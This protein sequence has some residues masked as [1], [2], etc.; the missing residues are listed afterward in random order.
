MIDFAAD[1]ITNIREQIGE[2]GLVAALA[3]STAQSSSNRQRNT[4]ENPNRKNYC[5]TEL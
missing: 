4:Y 2:D 5:K 1:L 3:K